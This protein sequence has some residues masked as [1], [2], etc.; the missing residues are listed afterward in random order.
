MKLVITITMVLFG[1]MVSALS[2]ASNQ[3]ELMQLKHSV[4]EEIIP[5]I[6]PLL[7]PDAVVTGK[8]YQLIIRA[9]PSSLDSIKA[10]I[11]RID[12][13]KHQLKIT[14]RQVEHLKGSGSAVSARSSIDLDKNAKIIIG[15]NTDPPSDSIRLSARKYSTQGRND[16]L[17]EV[18]TTEGQATFLRLGKLV[19]YELQRF[20]TTG[21]NI[22]YGHNVGYKELYSGLFVVPKVHGEFVSLEIS[23]QRQEP[24][25]EES[26]VINSA[27][28]RSVVH[29]R[30]GTWIVLGA[31]EQG[32]ETS[33][34]RL[35]SRTLNTGN[36][37]FSVQ[38]KVELLR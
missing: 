14:L 31:A 9:A 1:A 24:S 19:P 16:R 4:A 15:E 28:L 21:R 13:P 38:V 5:V 35:P 29:G 12:I 26:G 32:M 20:I 36:N 34:N 2:I 7:E 27:Q 6:K 25:A 33:T 37:G 11:Q 22:G 17:Y 18:Q 10:I 3:I 8:G 23:S 30:L